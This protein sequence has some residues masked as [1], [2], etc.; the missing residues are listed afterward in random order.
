MNKN[1]K[2]SGFSLIELIVVIIIIGVLRGTI[3][4][5][6]FSTTDD[7]KVTNEISTATT[8]KSIVQGAVAKNKGN[9]LAINTT[10][11]EYFSVDSMPNVL[12]YG[13]GIK[14]SSNN[15]ARYLIGKT[16]S[17]TDSKG[18]ELIKKVV[19]DM[20]RKFDGTDSGS[21]DGT[22]GKFLYDVTCDSRDGAVS[23]CYYKLYLTDMGMK[24]T[25]TWHEARDIP[26]TDST[27]DDTT[28]DGH[29]LLFIK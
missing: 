28:D 21:E 20:D 11:S 29:T 22:R 23:N 1:V 14:K 2:K 5:K 7:A 4:L 3:G 17:A 27:T 25:D 8:S 12:D 18:Q 13:I 6:L 26:N 19:L 15:S 9:I 16:K 10:N 24:S